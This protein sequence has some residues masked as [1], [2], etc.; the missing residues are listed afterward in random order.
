MR[1]YDQGFLADESGQS[2]IEYGLIIFLIALVIMIGVSKFGNKNLTLISG[3]GEKLI[4]A[5]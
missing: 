1:A 5:K 3:V 4:P 2:V